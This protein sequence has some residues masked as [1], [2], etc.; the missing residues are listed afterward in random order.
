[1]SA[2][3]ENRV[4]KALS[5]YHHLLVCLCLSHK[6]KKNW[7]P[8]QNGKNLLSGVAYTEEFHVKVGSNFV[9]IVHLCASWFKSD[10]HR[11]SQD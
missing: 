8:S 9:C 7:A 10:L 1:M 4:S 5:S 6:K 2:E 11:C 3:S